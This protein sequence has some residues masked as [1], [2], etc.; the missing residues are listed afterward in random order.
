MGNTR[1][2][3]NTRRTPA[4]VRD[5]P[6]SRSR[7]A[8]WLQLPS[9]DLYVAPEPLTDARPAPETPR[10][11][12]DETRPEERQPGDDE[13]AAGEAREHQAQQTQ[14]PAKANAARSSQPL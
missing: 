7:D 5:I 11:Q 8:T 6:L 1:N 4:H 9:V 12:A 14:A 3:R 13:P 2:T 10:A